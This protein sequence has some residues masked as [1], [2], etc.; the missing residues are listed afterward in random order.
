VNGPRAASER[1]LEITAD[2]SVAGARLDTV[3]AGHHEV[4]TRAAA[5]ALIARGRVSV[6]GRA[7]PKSHRVAAGE[8]IEAGLDEEGAAGE[9]PASM[10][11]GVPFS[12]VYEDADL[13]VVDKPAGVV[14]HPGRGH[15]HGT[16]AQALAGRTAGGPPERRGVVHR[17]D[18]DTSG[19]L[20][21]ARSEHAHAA[22]TE[23]LR[24]R[25]VRREYLALVGGVPDARSGTID[26][27][28]GRGR[29]DRT[30]V[31]TDTDR[32]QAARTRFRVHEALGGTALLEL[33]LETGRTHQIRAHAAAI[34]HPVCGD[35]RYGGGACG[36]RLGLE[37][38][39]LHAAR[40]GLAHP[41]SGAPLA[42][43]SPLPP[44][45]AAALERA[46]R[47]PRG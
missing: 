8:R 13:I 23:A 42:F 14:V 15:E 24:R 21:L 41:T 4:R 44:E 12:V 39:F 27:E 6:D 26:A 34:G 45:L 38:Q 1:R 30:R 37:R 9:P 33:A 19:L 36:R 28:V 29:S 43:E 2:E 31:S 47:E 35:A 10:D 7:R 20:V 5:Q 17:L 22:L 25:A 46:R 40:L 18:R 11:V 3:L 32:P 16:L